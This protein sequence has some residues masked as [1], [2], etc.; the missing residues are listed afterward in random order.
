MRVKLEKDP[1]GIVSDSL[2]KGPFR[3]KL[4]EEKARPVSPGQ[5]HGLA[6]KGQ[7]LPHG[8]HGR[9]QDALA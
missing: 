9:L 6:R 2:G 1:R 7:V 8:D 5:R 4:V 3:L